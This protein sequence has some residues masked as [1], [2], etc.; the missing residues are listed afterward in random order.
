MKDVKP[1]S[2]LKDRVREVEGN[3]DFS[4]KDISV[5]QSP[6]IAEVNSTIIPA[7]N[8]VE[9]QPEVN[10][11]SHPNVMTQVGVQ[12]HIIINVYCILFRLVKLGASMLQYTAPL[13]PIPVAVVEDEKGGS[14]I[15]P[16]RVP[17]AQGLSQAA[18]SQTP[19]SLSQVYLF[20]TF[21]FLL[22]HIL[23]F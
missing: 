4:N 18:A 12:F 1:T 3:P 22:L 10:S 21:S 7:M 13:H 2:L 6:V 19:F 15:I 20:T 5:S 16:E 23:F 17:S 11:T 9:L 8:Q 14:L